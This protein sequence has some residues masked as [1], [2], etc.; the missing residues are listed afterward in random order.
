MRTDF[1]YFV[2]IGNKGTWSQAAVDVTAPEPEPVVTDHKGAL[3]FQDNFDNY[4]SLVDYGS[5]DQVDLSTRGVT[6]AIDGVEQV[7]GGAWATMPNGWGGSGANTVW[8]Q[9]PGEIVQTDAAT[10]GGS[11]LDTQ[12]SPGGI[13][14]AN[15]FADPTADGKFV[16][17][18]DL[19][20]HDFGTGLMEETGDDAVFNVLID[21]KVVGSYT[22]DQ[23]FQTALAQKGAGT[24]KMAHFEIEVTDADPLAGHN[25]SFEDITPSEGHYVGFMLD[26]VQVWDFV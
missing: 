13:E 19:G 4:A 24:E 11:W 26:T 14:I 3:L 25:I 15:W 17:S 12:H 20:I 21:D 6:V 16:V 23:V 10:S 22:Y 18:F 9:A 1:H 2:Q 8:G 5:W 7:G